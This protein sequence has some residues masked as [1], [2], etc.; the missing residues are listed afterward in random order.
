MSS[1]RARKSLTSQAVVCLQVG[2]PEEPPPEAMD[3]G[4]PVGAR[5]RITYILLLPIV[6]PLWL[7]LPDTR[8]PRGMVHFANFL[9]CLF[10]SFIFRQ[11]ILPNNVFG[12]YYVDSCLLI[13]DGLVGKYCWRYF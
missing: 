9:F 4:W 2:E 11:K 12:K 3:M 6:L 1:V 10:V 7:T 5:K 8:S 13:F